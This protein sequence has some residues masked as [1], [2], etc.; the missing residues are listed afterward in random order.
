MRNYFAVVHKDKDSSFGVYFPDLPGCF[1]AGETED[2]AIEN[3]RITLRMYAEDESDLPEAR[4]VAALQ[5]DGEVRSEFDGGAFL[6]SVPL[7]VADRKQRYNLMLDRSLVSTVDHAARLAGT[8]RSE[9][10]AQALAMQLKATAGAVVLDRKAKAKR[11][12]RD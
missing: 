6:I 3:A 7:V 9:Y 10:V 1:A 12:A 2:E 5:K 11:R 4:G 8:N